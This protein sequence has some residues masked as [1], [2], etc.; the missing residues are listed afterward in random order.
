MLGVIP[1]SIPAYGIELQGELAQIARTRT[2]RPVRH[3]SFLEVPIDPDTDTF[4]GNPPFSLNLIEGLLNRIGKECREGTYL[5]LILPVFAFQTASRVVRWNE[6]WTIEQASLPRNLF[7]GI[8]E[9]LAFAQFTKERKP[10]LIG[11]VLYGETQHVRSLPTWLQNRL[12]GASGKVLERKGGWR[13]AVS[14]V[15]DF[16]GGEFTLQDL[17]RVFGIADH[18]PS[19][20]N[21][22]WKAK[23]RQIVQGK[24]FERIAPGVYRSA[25]IAA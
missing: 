15:A 5:G 10:K 13:E 12:E 3:G 24:G 21:R 18:R 1:H 8:R 22:N 2:G 6:T 23:L 9:T 20:S 11:F 17:Y 16:L 4:F 7:P 25:A 19:L 14:A